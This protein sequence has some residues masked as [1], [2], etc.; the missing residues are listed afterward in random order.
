MIRMETRSLT[1]AGDILAGLF[2]LLLVSVYW[3]GIAGVAST[4]QWCVASLLSLAL[5]FAPRIR[6]TAA[7]GWGAALVGWMLLS[8]AWNGGGADGRLDG[9]WAGFGLVMAGVAFTVGSTL[10]DLRPLFVGL[11]FGIGINSGFCIA[12]ALGF[13]GFGGLILTDGNR[14]GLFYERDRLAAAAAM[15]AVGLV[16][17]PRL[18]VL[19]PLTAPA[20][21]LTHA[22]GATLALIVGL[23]FAV[24]RPLLVLVPFTVATVGLAAYVFAFNVKPDGSIM[25]RID[26]WRDTVMNLTFL[27]HGLG[28]YR[29]VF[30]QTA[31]VYDFKHWNTRPE[32]PHNELLWLIFEGGFPAFY[33]AALF[34]RKVYRATKGRAEA[35]ILAAL[36]VA[37]FFAMSLHDPATLI[38]GALCAGH[39]A[40]RHTRLRVVAGDCGDP[41]CP[42]LASVNAGCFA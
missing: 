2:G 33:L 29:E 18:W 5:F 14:S 21:Y 11:A 40:G 25:E 6:F 1:T 23:M 10:R 8:I 28:S 39:L 35:G 27:G 37:A 19:L 30:L 31:T 42:W 22:R 36:A 7:H 24:R 20:L 38:L 13:D 9:V 4:P 17:L 41:L 16:A 32:S 3:P 34:A 15:V 26:I 12:Q